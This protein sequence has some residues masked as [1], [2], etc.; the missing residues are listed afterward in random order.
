MASPAFHALKQSFSGQQLVL[1]GTDEFNK[2][3]WP[4]LSCLESDVIPTVI[5]LPKSKDDVARFITAVKPLALMAQRPS[6]V[7][8]P[9]S[10]LISKSNKTD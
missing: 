1:A 5:C 9:S 10:P 7:S 4:Y 6:Q 8:I 2:L 3:N